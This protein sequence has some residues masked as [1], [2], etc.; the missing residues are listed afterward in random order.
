[1]IQTG[2]GRIN[3][4]SDEQISSDKNPTEEVD[5]IIKP[6]II[7]ELTGEFSQNYFGVIHHE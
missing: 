1:L 4:F 6:T 7:P 2:T 5:P 3:G